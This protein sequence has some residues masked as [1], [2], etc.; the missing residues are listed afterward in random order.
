MSPNKKR[1]SDMP[2]TEARDCKIF[3]KISDRISLRS[4]HFSKE[5]PG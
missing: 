2:S 3:H 4:D 1:F 5:G